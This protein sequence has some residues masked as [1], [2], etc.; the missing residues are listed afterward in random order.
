MNI[1]KHQLGAKTSPLNTGCSQRLHRYRRSAMC[2]SIGERLDWRDTRWGRRFG[3][4]LITFTRRSGVLM[5]AY[6]T[7][8]SNKHEE[9]SRSTP[10]NIVVAV[11]SF[12]LTQINDSSYYIS[13][14][15]HFFCHCLA[16]HQFFNE[17][18]K[19]SAKFIIS[20]LFSA[21]QLVSSITRH[22]SWHL[23]KP[24]GS[25]TKMCFERFGWLSDLFNTL[26]T[27]QMNTKF[28]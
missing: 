23:L 4:H 13:Y 20:C 7:Q 18:Y 3:C 15:V 1:Y 12:K 25:R 27:I 8:G 10:C 19:R 26:K 5:S 9:R 22:I 6:Q 24:F 11:I 17:I 28:H 21:N 16:K 14:I 2:L